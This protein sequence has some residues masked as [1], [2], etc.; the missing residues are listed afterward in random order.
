MTI[1]IIRGGTPRNGATGATVRVVC[2]RM[3]MG[4]MSS[5]ATGQK[6]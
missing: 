3:E 2:L 5:D 1:L 4:Y 6:K